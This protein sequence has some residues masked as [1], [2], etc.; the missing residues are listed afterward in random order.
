[1]SYRPIH[2]ARKITCYSDKKENLVA[3]NA[4]QAKSAFKP[5]IGKEEFDRYSIDSRSS[6]HLSISISRLLSFIL[7]TTRQIARKIYP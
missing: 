3:G 6:T 7:Q 1:M 4:Q 5:T 2:L